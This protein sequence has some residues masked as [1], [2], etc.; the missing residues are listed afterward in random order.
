M[1]IFQFYIVLNFFLLPGELRHITKLK[2]WRLFDVLTE[3]YE[4][5]PDIA[6]EFADWLLPM[7][8]FDPS[9]RASADQCLKHPFLQ[10]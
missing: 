6:Q 10:H 3:K 4:W 8:A 1:F 2:P 7:L 9:D 5:E